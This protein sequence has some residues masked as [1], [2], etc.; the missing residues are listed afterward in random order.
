[1]SKGSKISRRPQLRSSTKSLALSLFHLI[2]DEFSV[3]NFP[4]FTPVIAP[5]YGIQTHS[6]IRRHPVPPYVAAARNSFRLCTCSVCPKTGRTQHTTMTINCASMGV[7]RNRLDKFLIFLE[8][9]PVMASEASL[10]RSELP[11]K[12]QQ[13]MTQK[14]GLLAAWGTPKSSKHCRFSVGNTWFGAAQ[15]GQH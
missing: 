11:Q 14:R 10:L 12:P 1:M 4:L 2:L 3:Q 8:T 5:L 9:K 6:M 7:D 15:F 13:K